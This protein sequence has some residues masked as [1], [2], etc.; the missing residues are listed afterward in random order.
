MGLL[1]VISAC[2]PAQLNECILLLGTLF[3]CVDIDIKCKSI[4]MSFDISGDYCLLKSPNAGYPKSF[5]LAC[6]KP[7]TGNEVYQNKSWWL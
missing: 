6:L 3:G 1:L 4:L 5:V 2:L 7:L